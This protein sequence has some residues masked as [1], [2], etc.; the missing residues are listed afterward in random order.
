MLSSK[1]GE[2]GMQAGNEHKKVIQEIT[3]R[4]KNQ[5]IVQIF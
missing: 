1:F 4:E 5:R 3:K 2:E